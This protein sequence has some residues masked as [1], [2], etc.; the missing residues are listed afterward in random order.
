MLFFKKV[1]FSLR[2]FFVFDDDAEIILIEIE[3]GELG[4]IMVENFAGSESAFFVFGLES[5]SHVQ[6]VFFV[7]LGLFFEIFVADFVVL[8]FE[9]FKN[10]VAVLWLFGE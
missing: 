1:E 6:N 5:F 3:D 4:E 10:F 2:G 8:V 9:L 7:G